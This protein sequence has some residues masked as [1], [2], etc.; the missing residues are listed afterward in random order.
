MRG[1]G[2]RAEVRGQITA[3]EGLSY[4]WKTSPSPVAFLGPGT[5]RMGLLMVYPRECGKTFQIT[6]AM[7]W[8]IC[9]GLL[10]PR[11]C[12]ETAWI[13]FKEFWLWPLDIPVRCSQSFGKR[14][15]FV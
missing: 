2:L 6:C 14:F 15:D 4:A 13:I 8:D 5:V 3:D 9:Q 1:G 12:G 7:G 10:Y 11:A